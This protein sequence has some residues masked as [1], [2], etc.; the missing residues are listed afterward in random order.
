[1]F[2]DDLLRGQ[3]FLTLTRVNTDTGHVK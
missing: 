2:S 3:H 1:M